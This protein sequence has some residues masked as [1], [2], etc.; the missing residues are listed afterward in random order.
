MLQKT[1]T[2]STFRDHLVAVARAIFFGEWGYFLLSLT[3]VIIPAIL[4][5]N[6]FDAG[7]FQPVVQGLFCGLALRFINGLRKAL[8]DS[9]K[10]KT[11][12]LLT[13]NGVAV[14]II[15]Y[16]L[17]RTTGNVYHLMNSTHN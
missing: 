12:L 11:N 15:I 4:F 9:L 3:V 16:L 14:A 1:R 6:L 10:T 17:L 5:S 7:S 8:W 13:I 2:L